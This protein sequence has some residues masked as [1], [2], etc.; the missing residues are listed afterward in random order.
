MCRKLMWR[1]VH[2]VGFVCFQFLALSAWAEGRS[3]V[4][5]SPTSGFPPIEKEEGSPPPTRAAPVESETASPSLLVT[6]PTATV[7]GGV[8]MVVVTF[9]VGILVGISKDDGA[10]PP[11][12]TGLV[13]GC[14]M[15]AASAGMGL[16]G[17]MVLWVAVVTT[18]PDR[19][20]GFIMAGVFL[21]LALWGVIEIFVSRVWWDDQ[22]LYSRSPWSGR[23]KVPW[24]R[25]RSCRHADLNDWLV[26]RTDGHG[27][28]R[29]SVYMIGA[30]AL[31]KKLDQLLSPHQRPSTS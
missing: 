18:G 31:E 21:L 3:D 15:R 6:H 26:I 14:K 22:H 16:L 30:K 9:M 1:Y 2:I 10:A 17:L 24:D 23:K 8:V 20:L 13:Y 12:P 7:V 28:L 19:K 27:T 4:P 25:V 5:A 29:V 11:G